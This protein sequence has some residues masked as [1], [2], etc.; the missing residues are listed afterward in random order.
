M[1]FLISC[2]KNPNEVL[3]D[4]GQEIIKISVEIA[5]DSQERAQGMMF[6]ESL[7]ENSGMFF[8]FDDEAERIFWMKNTVIPLDMVF[9]DEG[10]R[11]VDVKTAAP[12][13]ENP[14]ASY[15][16]SKPA[17]YVLEVNER[18]AARKNIKIGDR[19]TIKE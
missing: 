19:I 12:C 6:R 4:N 15:S 16:S 3:I 2:T 9:I 11:I 18:F 5:D 10:Y 13:K 1:V 14:C 7:D 8:V 17:K